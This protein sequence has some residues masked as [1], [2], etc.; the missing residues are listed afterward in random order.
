MA[1]RFLLSA[2]ADSFSIAKV[3]RLSEQE[4]GTVF[5]SLLWPV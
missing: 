2:A 1:Q 4:A 5:R 3:I